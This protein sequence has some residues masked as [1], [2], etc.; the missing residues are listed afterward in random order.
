[1]LCQ[2]R[3]DEERDSPPLDLASFSH[4]NSGVC[5]QAMSLSLC[6]VWS[7]MPVLVGVGGCRAWDTSV[8]WL[9]LDR[10]PHEDGPSGAK[11]PT[12]AKRAPIVAPRPSGGVQVVRLRFDLLHVEL[13]ID[14]IRHARKIW[15]HVDE[16]RVDPEL[17]VLL[18]RNGLRI[19][20]ASL[21]AWPAIR[22]IFQAANARVR[23]S[24]Q[25]IAANL[26]LKIDLGTIRDPETIFSYH[27]NGRLTGRTVVGGTKLVQL[28]YSYHPELGGCTQVHLAFFIERDLGASDWEQRGGVIIEVPAIEH[29]RFDDIDVAL[30]LNPHEFLVIGPSDAA[31]QE[32]L[33]GSR[34]LNRRRMGG[35]VE[36]VVCITPTALMGG[37]TH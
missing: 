21:D 37:A 7:M 6:L 5:K 32:Y 11:T 20:A 22:A 34:F 31:V 19:G 3:R 33:V 14:D 25:I 23:D 27:R 35:L 18:A 9:G 12:S 28:D 29:Y 17:T 16:F 13:P 8:G 24:E 30:T 4:Y 1:M 15:N 36:T 10:S 2:T 26:P